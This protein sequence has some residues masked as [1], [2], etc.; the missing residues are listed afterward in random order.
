MAQF[1][2]VNNDSVTSVP[3]DIVKNS[4]QAY[5]CVPAIATTGNLALLGVWQTATT[6]GG[7]GVVKDDLVE[8]NCAVSVSVGDKLYL[9]ADTAG[10][11][12]NVKPAN[13][14]FIGLVVSAR[15]VSTVQK[16]TISFVRST[17][18]ADIPLA[19]TSTSGILASS[20]TTA[21]T[22]TGDS[23]FVSA[24]TKAASDMLATNGVIFSASGTVPAF[25]ANAASIAPGTD[26]ATDYRIESTRTLTAAANLTLLTTDSP[27]IGQYSIACEALALEFA[28]TVTNGGPAGG[29]VPATGAAFAASYTRGRVMHVWFDGVNFI[30]DG[31]SFIGAHT[32]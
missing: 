17:V 28:I 14:Y 7:S 3:G 1:Q 16:A 8:V 29:T 2:A 15:V 25:V 23:L 22:P 24:A 26:L 9:S 6:V 19:S 31:Y 5:G 11:A 13:P 21:L 30:F 27:P 32:P 20:L 12:T 10:K 4:G 18:V